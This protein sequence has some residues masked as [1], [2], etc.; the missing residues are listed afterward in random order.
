MRKRNET[1]IPRA[2]GGGEH[3]LKAQK[4]LIK[5]SFRPLPSL[6]FSLFRHYCRVAYYRLLKPRLWRWISRQIWEDILAPRVVAARPRP[7]FLSRA[8]RERLRAFIASDNTLEAAIFAQA[9]EATRHEFAFFSE[10][11][12]AHGSELQWHKDYASGKEWREADDAL[13]ASHRVDFMRSERGSD[14]KYVWELNRCHWFFWLGMARDA[15]QSAQDKERYARAFA[16][17]AQS[18]IRENPLGFGVNWSMPM[19]VAIR[20]CNWILGH[21]FFHDAPEL[22]EEFW[23]AYRQTLWRHGHFL[24]HHLEYVR[25]NANHFF[26]NALGLIVIGA[27]FSSTRS[28]KRWL[29]AGKRHLEREMALQFKPDGV[30]FEKSTSY[31]CFVVEMALIATIAAEAARSPFSAQYYERLQSA[32]SYIHAILRPDGSA[33]AFGDGDN[34]RVFRADARENFARHVHLLVLG[35]S[36]FGDSS[37][38]RE[39]NPISSKDLLYAYALT[40]AP[41]NALSPK[42]ETINKQNFTDKENLFL[43]FN[44]GGYIIAKHIA[45]SNKNNALFPLVER[46]AHFMIDVG[47]YGMD[48]WGG[49]GHNDCLSFELWIGGDSVFVDSGTGCY[50]ANPAL[51]NEL[52]ATS[53]HNVVCVEGAEQ[54]EWLSGSLW[55]VR[56]DTL[57]PKVLEAANQEGSQQEGRD[58]D[59]WSFR[60]VAEHS[61]YV[62]RFGVRC[63]RTILGR[64]D[65]V[66]EGRNIE[67]QSGIQ[68]LRITDEL[69]HTGTNKE[70]RRGIAAYHL[71]PAITI[72]E[73]SPHLIALQTPL[74]ARVEISS[75]YAMRVEDCRVSL[76]Y[77]DVRPASKICVYCSTA[78][79]AEIIVQW[80]L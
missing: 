12:R 50:T 78:Q 14:V 31:H 70:E 17:D 47:D 20:A 67:K 45:Y 13:A 75:P 55:R 33:P 34:G 60:I 62:E 11:L 52:R 59:A 27:F 28:G 22:D 46:S 74:G 48:G 51:R 29:R 6:S 65:G 37:L 54:V 18:W 24:S 1:R 56:R 36:L 58:D 41:A 16:R 15:A 30:N 2:L 38:L 68:S 69:I 8:D 80:R 53:A 19:E 63:R 71:S 49:H 66:A 23:T 57:S 10:T 3:E 77:G 61:A 64:W 39:I 73:C 26:S 9:D 5:L 4:T 44:E 40:N 42:G 76:F 79:A 25:R 21:S 7:L 72:A 43:H 35:A 32:L